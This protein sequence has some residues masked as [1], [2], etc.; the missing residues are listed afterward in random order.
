MMPTAP[1]AATAANAPATG[2]GIWG[3]ETVGTGL[4]V[5]ISHE[6]VDEEV[7]V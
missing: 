2:A 1:L 6:G 4:E 5:K 3:E 7:D